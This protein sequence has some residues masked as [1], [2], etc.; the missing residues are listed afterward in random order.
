MHSHRLL[1]IFGWSFTSCTPCD[2]ETTGAATSWSTAGATML[3]ETILAMRFDKCHERLWLLCGI[4]SKYI[5]VSINGGTPK[6]YVFLGDFPVETIHFGVPPFLETS[7]WGIQN[8]CVPASK[9]RA[10][11][12][13]PQNLEFECFKLV[14]TYFHPNADCWLQRRYFSVAKSCAGPGYEAPDQVSLLGHRYPPPSPI[15]CP[16]MVLARE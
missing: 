11:D 5:G 7:I 12:S 16:I 9:F 14:D 1:A 2:P 10:M 15:P 3:G 6:S 8:K 4:S 13:Q